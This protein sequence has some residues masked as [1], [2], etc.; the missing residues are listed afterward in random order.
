MRSDSV[1][2]ER[3]GEFDTGGDMSVANLLRLTALFEGATGVALLAL[4]A[5]MLWALF[6]QADDAAFPIL[7]ARLFGAPLLS[8]SFVCWTASRETSSHTIL[9]HVAAMLLYNL[10]V[11]ALL[12][13]AGAM[14]GLAGFALWPA[15]VAH[16]LLA[17]WCVAGLARERRRVVSWRP[18][19][20]R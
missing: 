17:G 19:S 8:L 2:P 12:V 7:L 18:G 3:P 9:S 11:A 1:N 14:L 20:G 13:Y 4:P 15:V 16:I 6:G 5:L 10:V